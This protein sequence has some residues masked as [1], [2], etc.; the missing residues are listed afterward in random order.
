MRNPDR[1]RWTT[2]TGFAGPI[3]FWSYARLAEVF[4]ISKVTG[5]EHLPG[6]TAQPNGQR[7]SRP[8]TCPEPGAESS[9]HGIHN[10]APEG[11]EDF[12]AALAATC[13]VTQACED[14]D[15]S[16]AWSTNSARRTST[17]RPAGTRP[18]A[19]A[20][21]PW[22]TK[23]CAEAAQAWMSPCSTQCAGWHGAQ[24]QATRWQSSCSKGAM[25][26]VPPTTP[27]LELAGRVELS[28]S[29]DELDQELL[30]LHEPR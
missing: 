7:T 15:V 29:D 19:S 25:P 26:E 4:D 27:K 28:G 10:P 12:L 24:I 21:K 18:N 14:S 17:L 6:Q 13:S 1:P 2:C 23:P 3:Q 9:G 16:P 20:R 22:K 30:A 5:R 11:N 8:C